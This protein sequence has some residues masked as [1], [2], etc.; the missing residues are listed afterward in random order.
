MADI[1]FSPFFTDKEDLNRIQL[2]I[3]EVVQ[4][5]ETHITNLER[6]DAIEK[7]LVTKEDVFGISAQ[8]NQTI[9]VEAGEENRPH[10]H[11]I[12]SF[13]APAEG[14]VTEVSLDDSKGI[15]INKTGVYALDLQLSIELIASVAGEWGISLLRTNGETGADEVILHSVILS[16]H[17]EA[18]THADEDYIESVEYPPQKFNEGE[19]VY[20]AVSFLSHAPG[21]LNF[22]ISPS[23]TTSQ[24]MV[25]QYEVA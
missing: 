11:E 10:F 20:V 19:Y 15:R 13:S 18:L 16:N 6:A 12:K 7:S 24:L 25:I 4:Q 2:Q 8:S 3:K 17:T 14:I 1:K 9:T 23:P 5:I 21:L 22:N